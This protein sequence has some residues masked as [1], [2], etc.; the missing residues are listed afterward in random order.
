MK[1]L[2]LSVSYFS[3]D[4]TFMNGKLYTGRDKIHEKFITENFTS[5]VRNPVDDNNRQEMTIWLMNSPI[6]WTDPSVLITS[7]LIL[8][9]GW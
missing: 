9:L 3:T 4:N 5:N 2:V 1:S 8:I 6:Y 7:V